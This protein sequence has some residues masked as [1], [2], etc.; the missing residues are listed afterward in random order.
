MGDDSESQPVIPKILGGATAAAIGARLDPA[1]AILLGAAG[2][3]FEELAQRSWLELV[4][5]ARRRAARVLA[6]AA[7][8]LG[9]SEAELEDLIGKS[10]DTLLMTGE[11]MSAAARTAWPQ[12]VVA[13]GR[14]LADGLIADGDAVLLPQYAMNAMVD[15]DRLDVILLDLLV[16]HQVGVDVYN[17]YVAVPAN[18]PADYEWPQRWHPGLRIWS[19][20]A[21]TDARP[22][23]SQVL[24]RVAG[25]L[26]RH[27][28]ASQVD[29]THETVE[30]LNM[31]QKW[32]GADA[33]RGE[34]LFKPVLNSNMITA[35]VRTWSP[36]ELGEHVLGYYL[37]AADQLADDAGQP[38]S[39][40]A[41]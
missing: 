38:E 4:P 37:E 20:H 15:L 29:Q 32:Q 35:V 11:A 17:M 33:R 41:D 22:E 36:T 19:E 26:T 5:Q 27:G 2:Y 6:A 39:T 23:L 25:T 8:K 3:Q 10:E 13:L 1:A 31:Q 28:L 40:S 12:Q 21:I 9:C 18:P 14:L 34:R 7:R 24:P 16:R 30:D